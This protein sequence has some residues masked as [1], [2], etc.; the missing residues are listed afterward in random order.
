MNP[1]DILFQTFTNLFAGVTVDVTTAMVALVALM[2]LI[3]GGS[4]LISVINDYG[5][6]SN[7]SEDDSEG[8]SFLS[9]RR[10]RDED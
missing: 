6:S 7:K 5:N 4:K 2:V 9:R 10:A 3:L 1:T 8:S